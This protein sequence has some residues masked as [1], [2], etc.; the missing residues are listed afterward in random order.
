MTAVQVASPADL[1]LGLLHALVEA[2]SRLRSIDVG[3][4]VPR[5]LPR[6]LADFTGRLTDAS[7][8]DQ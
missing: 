2:E 6:Q 5:E 1:E 7:A 8:L 4:D 3:T